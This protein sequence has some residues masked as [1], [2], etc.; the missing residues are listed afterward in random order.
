MSFDADYTVN[1]FF[2]FLTEAR[3]RDHAKFVS[4]LKRKKV[5]VNV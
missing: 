1:L 5:S 3:E 4:H 2:F